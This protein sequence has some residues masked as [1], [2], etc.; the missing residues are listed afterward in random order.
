MTNTK[1]NS[2]IV[3]GGGIAGCSSAYSLAKRGWQVTV[4]EQA[5]TL[6]QGASGNP[7]AVL[8]ARLTG[9]PSLLNDLALASFE[10]SQ[11]FLSALNLAA[12]DYQKCGVLQLSFNPR[13]LER[14]LK[15]I[16]SQKQNIAQYIDQTEASAIA[17]IPLNSGGLFM[18][19]AGWV[20]PSAFCKALAHHPN[21]NI[22]YTSAAI[23]LASATDCWQ[24]LSAQKLLAEASTVI[25]ANANQAKKFAQ[26]QHLPLTPVC[27][28][29]SAVP[30]QLITP[31]NPLKTIVCGDGYL[32]PLLDGYQYIG[33]TFSANDADLTL[34]DSEHIQN[35]SALNTITDLDITQL[36]QAEMLSQLSGRVALRSQTPDYL[37]L[38]GQLIDAQQLIQNPPRYNADVASLPW[39]KGLYINAGHGAKGMIT[40]PYCAEL[41]AEHLNN[42]LP[43]EFK[44]MFNALNP[45]RFLLR[46][47]GL[48]QLAKMALM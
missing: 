44:D 36:K 24:V 28:Q 23:T 3:I 13:E 38:A 34:R 21:I 16:A 19:N 18:P 15:F 32:S 7:I 11:K 22:I 29:L 33:T 14:H 31:L 8:Y 30:S 43:I 35:L 25:I 41:I 1:I 12:A 4:I 37:P 48:K 27:G 9:N 45:N 5:Q 46:D 2:A 6:A 39:M 10:Y 40:A 17:G 47:L 20:N 42:A 26:S